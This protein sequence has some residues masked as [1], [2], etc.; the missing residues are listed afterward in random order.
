MICRAMRVAAVLASSLLIG[1]CSSGRPSRAPSSTSQ[2]STTTLTTRAVPGSTGPAGVPLSSVSWSQV[3]YPFDC[4]QFGYALESVRAANP[5]MYAQPEH[6]KT[7]AVVAV[8][9][10]AGAGSPP[11][12]LLVYDGATAAAEP[13]LLQTLQSVEEDRLVTSLAASGPRVTESF[14]GYSSSAITRCCPDVHAS[15]A[16][17]WSGRRYQPEVH[18]TLRCPS[19]QLRLG[20]G[21]KVSEPTGQHSSALTL[22]NVGPGSCYLRGYPGVALLDASGRALPFQYQHGGDQVVTSNPPTGIELPR[23]GLAFFTINKYRCDRGDRQVATSL[24]VMPPDEVGAVTA[25]LG[26]PYSTI[27]YCGPADPGSVVSVSPVEA[28]FEDTVAH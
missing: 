7:V 14:D 26:S 4:D 16:W 28:T 22:A 11:T 9:C 15:A 25:N 13:H 10:N 18:A 8:R 23:G 24:S 1:A 27:G 20:F 5:V 2:S 6:G 21:P 12:A 17:V 3:A 19:A